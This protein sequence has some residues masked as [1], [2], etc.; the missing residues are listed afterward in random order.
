M[1]GTTQG[2]LLQFSQ[3]PSLIKP[4]HKCKVKVPK[5]QK[6]MMT[7]EVSSML[8]EGTIKFG[9]GNKVFFTYP[10]LISK[11]NGESHFIM[12][13]K[14]LNQ[15]ISCTKLKMATLKQIKEA[16][17]P[18]QWAVSLNIKSAYCHIP[19]ARRHCCF[20]HF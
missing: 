4:T 14:L 2:H 19:I 20:L 3:K 17:H 18:E 5:T 7:S 9:P 8:S 16:I 11:K 12:N 13:L 1:L 10:F 15:Y 6:S